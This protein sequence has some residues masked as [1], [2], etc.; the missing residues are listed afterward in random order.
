M[1]ITTNVKHRVRTT[2]SEH[3][4]PNSISH[5]DQNLGFTCIF[6]LGV[7]EVKFCSS[8]VRCFKPVSHQPCG[9][10]APVCDD[11]FLG[12]VRQP[13]GVV[14]NTPRL[15]Y[16]KQGRK[17]AATSFRHVHFLCDLFAFSDR[18]TTAARHTRLSRDCC[19]TRKVFV[20]LTL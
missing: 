4:G 18:R 10:R 8:W 7:Q 16:E 5:P 3:Q 15:S 13:H 17:A 14:N 9:S 2:G 6:S 11:K 12:F 19:N 1:S 20:R